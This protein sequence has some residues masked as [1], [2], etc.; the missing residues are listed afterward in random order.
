MQRRREH[1]FAV[2]SYLLLAGALGGCSSEDSP[3]AA[4]A[5][6]PPLKVVLKLPDGA[7]DVKQSANK[8]EFSLPARSAKSAIEAWQEELKKE[9]WAL[10]DSVHSEFTGRVFLTRD[11][12]GLNITY[13]DGENLPADVIVQGK[14]VE[15]VVL[16]TEPSMSEK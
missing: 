6:E 3:A 5:V 8:V 10:N 15:L 7:G 11:L 2:L 9:G 14:G 4:P 12:Q 13:I 1:G 16:P